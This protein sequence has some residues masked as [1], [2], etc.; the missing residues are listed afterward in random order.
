M[1]NSIPQADFAL[2]TYTLGLLVKGDRFD[3]LAPERIAELS[4]AHLAYMLG[5]RAGGQ[6]LAAGAVRQEVGDGAVRGI[7]FYAVPPEQ[8][9]RLAEQDPAVRAGLFKLEAFT[10]IGPEGGIAFPLQGK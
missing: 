3:E 1:G 9:E 5:L 10:F 7:G 4:Q 6:V 2:E 8:A